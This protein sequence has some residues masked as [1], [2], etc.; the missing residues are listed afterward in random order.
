MAT[1]SQGS[2]T[3]I[4]AVLW[5]RIDVPAYEHSRLLEFSDGYII[6]GRVITVLDSRPAEAHYA[7][8]CDHGWATRRVL[9]TLLQGSETRR[10][11]IR[12]DEHAQWWQDDEIR[13]ELEGLVDI[14]LSLT[15][16]TNTL[17]IRRL[18]LGMG[19][20]MAV[21]AVWVRFPQLIVEPLPQR[22]TRMTESRYRYESDGGAF[23]ALLDVDG[24][25]VVV[26]YGDIWE[27]LAPFP[28]QSRA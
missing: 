12:R 25:G 17:P 2:A 9:V 13:P 14:D 11:D 26:R 1:P 24:A 5:R 21:T 10:I 23:T 6:D 15:P 8:V 3:L 20:S 22:Y 28:S 18:A 27:R 7:V 4:S 19:G 16:A